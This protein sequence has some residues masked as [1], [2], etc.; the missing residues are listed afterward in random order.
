MDSFCIKIN[1]KK[2]LVAFAITSILFFLISFWFYQYSE[3]LNTKDLVATPPK[4][5]IKYVIAILSHNL[6]N[7][8]QY[9]CF[10]LA[11]LL[12]IKDDLILSIQISQSLINLGPNY[13]FANL[14]PHGFL[15]IP[16][17]FTYQ[18]LSINLFYQLFFKDWKTVLPTF[19]NFKKIYLVSL[20]VVFISAI[21]DG[22]P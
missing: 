20:F 18:F 5:E 6:V 3:I 8:F 1:A 21:I 22:E 12:I 17:I 15:E 7:Y 19:K 16:N 13:T 11:P 2:R 9:L 4:K 14:F 10:P